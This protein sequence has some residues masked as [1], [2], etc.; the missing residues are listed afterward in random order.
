MRFN[1][2][3]QNVFINYLLKMNLRKDI[4]IDLVMCGVFT[5][6][7]WFLDNIFGMI[8][9]AGFYLVFV[10]AHHNRVKIRLQ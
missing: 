1:V 4:L 2:A 3:W 10:L 8:I 7:G 9:Y 5:A 6:S